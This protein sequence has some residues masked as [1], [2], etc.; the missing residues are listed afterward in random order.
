MSINPHAM[1][2]YQ[3]G[4]IIYFGAP[5]SANY[6]I[7]YKIDVKAEEPIVKHLTIET[8]TETRVFLYEGK[9]YLPQEDK[10]IIEDFVE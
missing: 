3:K 9:L 2:F 1:F 7:L 10:L 4:D 5:F 6:Y 8:E